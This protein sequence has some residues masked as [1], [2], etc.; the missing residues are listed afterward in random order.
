MEGTV[1]LIVG[2]KPVYFNIS[3]LEIADL[4]ASRRGLALDAQPTDNGWMIEA[5][6]K[7]R[8]VTS[9]GKTLDEAA[10]KLVDAIW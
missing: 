5:A 10:T 1:S 7:N 8:S 2:G 6:A 3:A 4:V 9:R